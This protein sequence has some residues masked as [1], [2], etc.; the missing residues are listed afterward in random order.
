M[1]VQALKGFTFMVSTYISY[2]TVVVYYVIVVYTFQVVRNT[3]IV[4]GHTAWLIATIIMI[5]I[6]EYKNV[7]VSDIRFGQ[8]MYMY[9]SVMLIQQMER[10]SDICATFQSVVSLTLSPPES[11]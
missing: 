8:P 11:H 4:L 2:S 6:T 3:L 9:H 1:S 5:M 7:L 10:L